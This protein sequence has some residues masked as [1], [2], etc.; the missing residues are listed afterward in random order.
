MVFNF[1]IVDLT[2]LL[3]YEINNTLYKILFIVSL[4]YL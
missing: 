1:N 3:Y 2:T 4:N